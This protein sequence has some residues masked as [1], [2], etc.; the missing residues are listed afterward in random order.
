MYMGEMHCTHVHAWYKHNIQI[1][2]A[3]YKH[4]TQIYKARYKHNIQIYKARYKHNI[5]IYKAQ[6]KHN[7]AI[8]KTLQ[9]FVYL[10]VVFVSVQCRLLVYTLI[11]MFVS[12]WSDKYYFL[13]LKN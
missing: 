1:Y 7:I 6:Y 10:D 2:K 13:E 9:C 12:P 4:N 8:Y 11:G 3:R 5:Q